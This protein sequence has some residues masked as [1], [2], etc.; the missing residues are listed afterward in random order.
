MTGD[1]IR[2]AGICLVCGGHNAHRLDCSLHDSETCPVCSEGMQYE[3]P[4]AVIPHYQEAK[5]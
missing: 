4:W 1:I 5:A 2:A 3:L